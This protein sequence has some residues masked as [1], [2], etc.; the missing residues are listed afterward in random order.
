MGSSLNLVASRVK[1]TSELSRAELEHLEFMG[2][3]VHLA[4]N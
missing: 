2:Q 3:L 4:Q 1:E